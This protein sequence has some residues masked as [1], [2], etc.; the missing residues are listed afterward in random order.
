MM[1]YLFF[2]ALLLA[3]VYLVAALRR[4][5]AGGPVAPRAKPKLHPSVT[6]GERW[7]Q[8]F[9]TARAEEAQALQAHLEENDVAVLVFEQ[10]KK[11]IHGNV[12]SGIG[13]VVPRSKLARAQ[14]IVV[15]FLELQK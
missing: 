8:V 6:R 13:L 12:L 9:E 4:G 1:R 3:V 5:H 7:A 11:D 10:G 14:A 2:P 15:R